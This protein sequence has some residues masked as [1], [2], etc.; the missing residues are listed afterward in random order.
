MIISIAK[1]FSSRWQILGALVV[2]L[3]ISSFTVSASTLRVGAPARTAGLGNPYVGLISQITQTRSAI[4]DGL[5]RISS[6]GHLEPELALS[7]E[8]ITP[9]T[10]IF[11]LRP[12]VYFSNGE[13]FGAES[14]ITS[15]GFLQNTTGQM[16]GAAVEMRGVKQVRA[17]DNLTVEIT[18]LR[19]DAILPKRLS[20]VMMVPPHAW[21]EMGLTEFSQAPVGTGSFLLKDWGANRGRTILEANSNSWRA[22]V[23]VDRLEVVFPLR[24]SVV[25]RQALEAGEIDVTPQL[26][27]DDIAVLSAEGFTTFAAAVPE[28]RALALRNVDNEG[29]PLRDVRV[30]QALNYG[31]NKQEIADIFYLSVA[32]PVGQGAIPGT[33][34][35]NPDITPYPYDPGRAKALLAEAGYEN[36]LTFRA[37]VEQGQA[38]VIY[39]KASQ[40]LARIGVDLQVR[41]LVAQEW[42]RKYFSSDW[43]NA[44]I[45]SVVWNSGAYWDTIR[46]LESY[47]C[48][49]PSPFFCEPSLMPLIEKSHAQ[50]D[51]LM[52]ERTLQDIMRYMHDLAPA[53]FLISHTH[54]F[55][56][57]PHIKDVEQTQRGFVFE[58]IVVEREN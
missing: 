26:T 46:A 6:T 52:R 45:L 22:P 33:F 13:P 20:M 41:T 30:R 9:N 24:D 40:D 12:N 54:S 51:P 25:R 14:V 42:L 2:L 35:Y 56:A 55:A 31:V 57:A 32:R 16:Y 7:W 8:V 37:E 18:T 49:K 5:T 48:A 10:W 50:F 58:K 1:S 4:F 34:G 23:D 44:D 21:T 47:S 19:P 29:S 15:I 39:V 27:L 53:L 17:V 11:N 38:Q 3:F 36:G 28:V 43:G